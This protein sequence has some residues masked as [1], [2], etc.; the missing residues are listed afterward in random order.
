M[1]TM[2]IASTIDL[3]SAYLGNIFP[4][5]NNF[6]DDRDVIFELKVPSLD[7]SFKDNRM[8][9]IADIY[10]NVVTHNTI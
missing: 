4:L 6:P 9:L 8:R 5:M 2:G 1:H 7:F 10:T 3:N